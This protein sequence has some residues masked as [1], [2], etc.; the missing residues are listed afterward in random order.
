MALFPPMMVAVLLATGMG[1]ALL[2]SVKVALASR[3]KIDEARVGG[4]VSIFGF[5]MIPAIPT[6]GFLTDHV[7][8]QEVVMAGSLLL[9]ASLILLALAKGYPW[10]LAAVVLLSAGWSL[11]VNVGNVLTPVAFPGTTPAYSYNL[12]NVFFGLGALLTPLAV[13]FL[14]GRTSFPVALSILGGLMV[15]PGILAGLIDFS[16]MSL[17]AANDAAGAA[18]NEGMA[19]LLADP[20]LW[21]CG[22]ALFFYGPLE[23]SMGAWATTYLGDQGIGAKAASGLLSGFWLVFMASRLVT[24]F[25]LPPEQELVLILVLALA[26]VAALLGVVFSRTSPMAVAMVLAA[27]LCFGPIF[28]TIMAVLS[29]HT[30]STLHGRA[31]GM[32]FAIGGIGWTT[33][34]ILIGA[35]ARRTSVQRGF[36]V[37]VGAAVGLAAVAGLMLT[38]E[39]Q[40]SSE[41][42]MKPAAVPTTL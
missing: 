36:L 39:H 38:N 10:A 26:C 25:T 41:A 19:T 42:F 13:A 35:Y 12:A 14:L 28:P 5:I 18:P 40:A 21:L 17:A 23:A 7:G 9:A 37:A 24:A 2:G 30:P 33:I 34:P 15:L 29:A 8:K 22:I 20:F 31:V 16:T 3:L 32:F 1:V 6:A 27:G 11:L 4:L